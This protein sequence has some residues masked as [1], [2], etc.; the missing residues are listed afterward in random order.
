MREAMITV[1][2]LLI[3]VGAMGAIG[4]STINTGPGVAREEFDSVIL[5]TMP[6][7][8]A[9]FIAEIVFTVIAFVGGALVLRNR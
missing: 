3:F 2:M 1:G 9:L 6:K 7:L 4:A 5:G 8:L